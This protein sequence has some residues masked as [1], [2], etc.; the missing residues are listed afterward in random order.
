MIS[1][2]DLARWRQTARARTG[3]ELSAAIVAL[4]QER[5]LLLG[6]RACAEAAVAAAGDLERMR[7]SIL[8]LREALYL[9]NP[10]SD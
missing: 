10:N 9:L 2:A 4:L 8:A 3:T 1:D 5:E 6:V 7:V